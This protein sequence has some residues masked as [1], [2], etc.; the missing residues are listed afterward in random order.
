MII[1]RPTEEQFKAHKLRKSTEVHKAANPLRDVILGGQDGLVNALGIILGI[2]AAGGDS[3]ILVT[4]VIAASIAE[5]ISMGAVAYTS[6]LA[7]K[8]YYYSERRSEEKEIEKYPQMEREEIRRIYE[9]KGIKGKA[10]EEI[11]EAVTSDKK[12]WA[13]VMMAEELHIE[14]INTKDVMKSSIIVTI[15][16]AI[17]HLIPLLPFF[18]L[19][20]REGIIVAIIISGLTLFAVG[21]YQAITL[22]GSWWKTGLRMLFIGLGAALAGYLIARLFRTTV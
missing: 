11:V 2:L 5:S 19:V 16:T 22:I 6:A 3:K 17:G 4:T 7:Q 21:A 9:A 8:D 12:I 18:F 13:D 10:L 1:N 14:P 15:A 20:P